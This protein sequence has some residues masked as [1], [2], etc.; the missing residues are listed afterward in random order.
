MR[1]W[2]GTRCRCSRLRT[3]CGRAWSRSRRMR[4][5]RPRGSA[6]MRRR[7]RGVYGQRRNRRHSSGGS[8]RSRMRWGS[9]ARVATLSARHACKSRL[10]GSRFRRRLRRS[11]RGRGMLAPVLTLFRRIHHHDSRVHGNWIIHLDR[12]RHRHVNLHRW[13]PVW[14]RVFSRSGNLRLSRGLLRLDNWRHLGSSFG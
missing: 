8:R 12:F 2:R 3:W 4:R 7:L 6:G 14:P 11:R 10:P 13:R 5:C 1:G 9:C